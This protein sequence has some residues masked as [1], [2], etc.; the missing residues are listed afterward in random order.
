M[1]LSND[2]NMNSA[3]KLTAEQSKMLEIYKTENVIQSMKERAEQN[4]TDSILT[5]H[6]GVMKSI[7]EDRSMSHAMNRGSKTPLLDA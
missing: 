7:F 2:T 6:R 3:P 1:S 4:G 5:A